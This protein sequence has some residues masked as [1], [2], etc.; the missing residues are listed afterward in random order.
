MIEQ[1]Y[2]KNFKAF[3]RESIPIDKHNIFIGEN[4]AGKSTVLQALDI[5]FNQ[6]KIDKSFVRDTT[7][8]VEIGITI[9]RVSY[10]KKFS[11]STYK[12]SESSD[13]ISDLDNLVY[14]YLPVSAYDP[15]Q[16]LNQLATA[17]ALSNTS[18]T[19]LDELKKI[20]QSSIDEVIA[21]INPDL[22]VVN[23]A[24]T[25]LTGE[26]NFK[27]DASIKFNVKS[28][29]IP[30]ES[31]GSGFQKNLIYALLVGND[32]SNVILGIDEIENSFSINNCS[33]IIEKLQDKMAQTLIT[34]HSKKVMEISNNSNIIPLFSE[35]C[36][37]L[38][39]LLD[40]LD[41]TDLKKYLLVE[42][43]FDLPWFKKCV[44]LLGKTDEYVILPGGGETN[45]EHLKRELEN[46]GKNCIII[47]DG[48]TKDR[49]SISKDCIELYTPLEKLNELLTLTLENVPDNKD[50]FF[51]ATIIEGDYGRNRDSVKGILS[52]SSFEFL[53]SDNELVNE[54]MEL[55]EKN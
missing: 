48:D 11:N 46:L 43:K 19:L 8:P 1:I 9:D 35:N 17:K 31:R 12:F 27:Y 24:G 33:N 37:T 55:L 26:E 13:N 30:I 14:I 40:E 10:K 42:G 51:A 39:E 34:T 20:L 7:R 16:L 36:K 52:K 21:G 49:N 29:G 3:E 25:E 54:V 5:F 4:D 41:N 53:T 23:S 2:I 45:A 50:D 15:K 38:S 32:Y 18:Q 44:Q 22:F 47:K 28:D 6:D